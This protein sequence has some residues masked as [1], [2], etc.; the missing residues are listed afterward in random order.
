MA[1][2]AV[3][4]KT[5]ELNAPH[6]HGLQRYRLPVE[7]TNLQPKN[8]K[9]E[10]APITADAGNTFHCSVCIHSTSLKNFYFCRLEFLGNRKHFLQHL[11]CEGCKV[12]FFGGGGWSVISYVLLF[13]SLSSID[14]N[15][16]GRHQHR[17][18]TILEPTLRTSCPNHNSLSFPSFF[19]ANAGTEPAN[20]LPHSFTQLMLQL[21]F[22][23]RRYVT[24]GVDTTP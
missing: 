7:L 10:I 20:R 6:L 15:T 8:I 5:E 11:N 17:G 13:N 24:S 4:L 21:E 9:N 1:L 22:P 23:T 3:H 2:I 12:L 19:G 16:H 14:F 18:G